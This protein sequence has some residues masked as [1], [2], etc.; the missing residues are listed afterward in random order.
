MGRLRAVVPPLTEI[1]FDLAGGRRRFESLCQQPLTAARLDLV[2]DYSFT[3][4][5]TDE[6]GCPGTEDYDLSVTTSVLEIPT[7]S[8]WAMILLA[9]VLA[10]AGYAGIH[11]LGM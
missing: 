8:A 5:A 10:L 2:G 7:L 11:R 9:A 6:N 4:T 3:I 1:V